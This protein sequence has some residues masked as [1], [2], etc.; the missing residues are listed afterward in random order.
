MNTYLAK[1]VR[2]LKDTNTV[3]GLAECVCARKAR[4]T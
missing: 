3:A 4:D 2:S 1:A